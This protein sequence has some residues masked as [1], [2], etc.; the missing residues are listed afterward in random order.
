MSLTC[1]CDN[2]LESPLNS[3]CDAPD[4]GNQIVR[5]FAQKMT[6]TDFDG[7]GGNAVTV[8]ADWQARINADDDDR[9][10]ILQNIS[11]GLMPATE[12]NV[13][14]GNAVPGGGKEVIDQ[15]RTITGEA[16]YLS[17]ADFGLWDKVNCWGAIRFWVLTNR[18]WLFAYDITTGAGV[19][20]ATLIKKSYAMGGIGVKNMLP[21][22]LSW[23]DLCEMKPV[24]GSNALTFLQTM[25]ASNVSGSQL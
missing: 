11:N 17:I 13:E 1:D 23:N 18:G 7:T 20:N 10:V 12:P 21:F 25:Q 14:E 16:K 15:P 5:I 6:G 9:I 2:A 4:F 24:T 8:E 19:P 22:E 3:K